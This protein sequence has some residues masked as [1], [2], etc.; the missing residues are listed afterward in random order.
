VIFQR[1][2]ARR[3][4]VADRGSPPPV[5][6]RRVAGLLR[7]LRWGLAGMVGLSAGGVLV[8]LVPPLL[9][10]VL[11]DALVEYGDKHEAALL[12]AV[13]AVAILGQ[14]T[15]YVLSDGM[16][17]RNAGRLHRSLR[18]QM[19]AGL[20]LRGTG[21]GEDSAG[22]PS[23]FISD[24]L[25]L[26]Q[27]TVALLDTGSMVVVQFVSAVVAVALLEPV[28]LAV[29]F[30]ML[31]VIWV[32]TRRTQE[33]AASAGLRRQ[34]ELEQM[35]RSIVRE[36]PEPDE[37]RANRG[38]RTAVDRVMQAE[39]R[40]GWLQAINTQGSGGLALL[41]PIAV[42][43]VAAF[44]GTAHVGTLLSLYLLAQRAF[45]GFDGIVDLSLANKS[46]RGAVSR[47]FE[48][49]DSASGGAPV[50]AAA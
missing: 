11:V 29:I 8:G 7:P 33:P 34:E 5:P 22:I 47:C 9:L 48:Y 40:Y 16:Y 23:R 27:V 26:D 19:F 13:I 32:V 35:T 37:E 3:R 28:T 46:V 15:A 25:T 2:L 30:P 24:V 4:Q 20:R 17:Y 6:W 39:I 38:L 43:V 1:S 49:I 44:A 31:F 10:G 42:V 50:P 41:G 12:A 14:T 45:G 21:D 36:L 18:L